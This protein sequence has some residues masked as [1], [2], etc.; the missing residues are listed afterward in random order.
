MIIRE[1]RSAYLHVVM[2][3]LVI[4]ETCIGHSCSN[5]EIMIYERIYASEVPYQ[6][7]PL[8]ELWTKLT[9]CIGK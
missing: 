8:K 3:A 6:S 2:T 1:I 5:G 4:Y 7:Y 9:I